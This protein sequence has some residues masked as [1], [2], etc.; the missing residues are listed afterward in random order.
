VDYSRAMR[1]LWLVAALLLGGCEGAMPDGHHHPTPQPV[2]TAKCRPPRQRVV[3]LSHRMQDG[4]AAWPGSVPFKLTRVSDHDAGY[5]AHEMQ[6]GDGVGTHLDAPS[7][8][9]EGKRSIHEIPVEELVAPVVVIDVRAKTE[10][11]PDYV[12]GGDVVVDWEAIHGPVPVASVVIFNTGWHEKFGNPAGYL[13]QDGE[14]VMHFPG[15]SGEAARLLIERDVLGVGIDTLSIDPGS[16]TTFEA[17]HAI[18]GAD[19]YQLENLA[20]LGAL[21]ET[22]ATIIVAVLPVVDGTQAQARV[23]ALVPEESEEKEEP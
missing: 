19:R 5:R 23:L 7:H 11:D 16:S 4:M 20:N 3:D 22:G 18:L 13:N 9:V 2:K 10:R 1:T 14:G 6:M 12:I 17:H 21:P 15:L 8:F